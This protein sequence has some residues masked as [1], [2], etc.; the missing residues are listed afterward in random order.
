MVFFNY[1]TMQMAAK[2]VYYGPGLCGKTTNL[3]VIYG[4]T[5]PTARGEMVSLETETDRTLFFDLLPIDVGVIGGFKTRLQLYTVPGQVFY[6]TTRKLVLKGV[7]GIVFVA[8]SQRPMLEPNK[9]SFRNLREN[10]AE[11]GLDVGEVPLVLQFNK[12]DLSNILSVD[13]L[14]AALNPDGKLDAFEASAA[15]GT[16]VFETLKGISKLTLRAL[17]SRMTGEARRPTVF[18]SP[19][20][21]AAPAEAP[22]PAAP[23]PPSGATV[24]TAP[25]SSATLD[26]LARFSE[27]AR[28]AAASP[29]PSE[30]RGPD[31]GAEPFPGGAAPA[32]ASAPSAPRPV[33]EPAAEISFGESTGPAPTPDEPAVKH[34]KV[35][36]SVDIL[37]E[38]DKLRKLSTQKTAAGAP[39]HHADAGRKGGGPSIDDLLAS[40]LNHKKDV[41]R[42]FDLTVPRQVLGR[43]RQVTIELKFSDGTGSPLP[44]DSSFSIDLSSSADLQKLLLSLRFN[45]QAE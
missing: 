44:T 6:N 17:R 23:R 10:L 36:S 20:T 13:E 34:V 26:R 35:R 32:P 27:L 45:V 3:H 22:A 5:A 8:D 19:A 21:P 42:S 33:E 25:T 12:R 15:N 1:A 16:G 38:L 2:I 28:S 30:A 41:T 18:A 7:D 43:S 4:R 9:E 14:N 40:N 29:A 37:S 24:R 39:P 31:G 11:I